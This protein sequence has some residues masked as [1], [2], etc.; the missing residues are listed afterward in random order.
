MTIKR[1][2]VSINGVKIMKKFKMLVVACL[3]VA[4]L[5]FFA[6]CGETVVVNRYL[7]VNNPTLA[8]KLMSDGTF[9]MS[10]Y[11]DVTEY[12]TDYEFKEASKIVIGREW[13]DRIDDI[14]KLV[15]KER[16]GSI[17]AYAFYGA[18]NLSE[19][20]IGPDVAYI[21]ESAFENCFNL[22]KITVDANNSYLKIENGYLIQLSD[23]RIIRGTDRAEIVLGENVEKIEKSAFGGLG[24]IKKIDM[25]Q[26]AVKEIPANA[27]INCSSLAEVALPSGLV[28][29]G[30]SAFAKCSSLSSVNLKDCA[31]LTTINDDAFFGCSS[32]TEVELPAAVKKIGI[33]AFSKS[34][35]AK[36]SFAESDTKITIGSN[37]FYECNALKEVYIS[38][39]TMPE[40]FKKTDSAGYL[41]SVKYAASK[42]E[43]I[44]KMNV[45]IAADIFDAET[46]GAYLIN[47]DNYIRLSDNASV[48]GVD[49]VV[50]QAK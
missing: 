31:M 30:E 49:F 44:R 23:N 27:F 13:E 32:L 17:G 43:V 28:D 3:T 36:I 38:N 14:K 26:S 50:Y 47:A 19:L 6:G 2:K 34:G 45:Y 40:T 21:N 42:G 29:I 4:F 5:A 33:L 22:K 9:T 39:S 7:D 10:N 24:S 16:V 37:A 8:F 20:Y 46:A 41:I 12:W 18:A 15:V 1:L 25:S 35:L 48:D 11:G